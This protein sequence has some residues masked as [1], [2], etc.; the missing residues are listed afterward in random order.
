[1]KLSLAERDRLLGLRAAPLAKP[2]DDDAAL[3]RLLADTPAAVLVDRTWLSGGDGTA[4][5][6][7]RVRLRSLAVPVFPLEGRDVLELGVPAGPRVGELLRAIRTWWLDGGC[8]A[9]ADACRT[10]LRRRVLG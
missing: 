1:L 8:V 4:W 10:E 7:L 9:D 2:E 5:D 3:R 6:S